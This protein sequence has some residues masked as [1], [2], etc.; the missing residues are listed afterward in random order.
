MRSTQDVKDGMTSEQA[1]ERGMSFGIDMILS[2]AKTGSIEDLGQGLH[3]LMDAD[4]HEGA[5]ME[6]HLGKNKHGHYTKE[7]KQMLYNDQ[8]GETKDA[9]KWSKAGV[10]IF[11]IL[12]GN[13]DVIKKLTDKNGNIQLDLSGISDANIQKIQTAISEKGVKNVQI[14]K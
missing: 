4:A 7:A 8:F 11:G 12:Q 10:A 13:Q 3:T 5:S 14:T 9:E 1:K 6:Q 2:A